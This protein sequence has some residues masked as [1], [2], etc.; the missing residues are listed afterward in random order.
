MMSC[1]V[2]TI[3]PYA[4]KAIQWPTCPS[5][6]TTAAL[7]ISPQTVTLT[8]VSTLYRGHLR[9]ELTSR[10]DRARYDWRFRTGRWDGLVRYYRERDTD[11]TV[12]AGLLDYI[13]DAL[14]QTPRFAPPTFTVR[15]DPAVLA[16]PVWTEPTFKGDFVP[17]DYQWEAAHAIRDAQWGSLPWK[18][19]VLKLAT[20][21]GKTN[22]LAMLAAGYAKAR[23]LLLVDRRDLM[24]QA[25]TRLQTLLGEK[26]GVLGDGRDDSGRRITVA[27][28]Q[29]LRT[30]PKCAA[31]RYADVL[32][33]D[34]CHILSGKGYAE[35]LREA[36][37]LVRVGVSATPWSKQREETHRMDVEQALGPIRYSLGPAA[38]VERGVLAPVTYQ[39]CVLPVPPYVGIWETKTLP[40]RADWR[41]HPT[42]GRLKAPS[43]YDACVVHNPQRDAIIAAWVAA[44]PA[45]TLVLV[46][47]IAHGERLA[48]QLRCQFVHGGTD[49]ETRKRV[50]QRLG[51][52]ELTRLVASTIFDVGVDL[53]AVRRLVL[54]GGG[55]SDLRVLQRIGRGM[56]RT[57]PDDALAVLDFR[58]VGH[59][60]LE[61]H[62]KF[63]MGTAQRAGFTVSLVQ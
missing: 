12:E 39:Q 30:R 34:E 22:V 50:L 20:G 41:D 36:T 29:T 2:P 1:P 57:G 32:L 7:A 47:S 40:Y 43:A 13:W 53:P 17:R 44:D 56:R 24:Y 37:A 18:R 10:D 21:S 59:P 16:V 45:P 6:D 23:V 54:A 27:M 52:G 55:K 15:A 5:E 28:F 51:S 42:A 49:T 9:T 11:F 25:Q 33:V 31:L 35:T 60:T 14:T 3:P 38:L 19:G 4:G 58:E 63:R 26:V 61:R 8:S 48:K 62:A 46:T